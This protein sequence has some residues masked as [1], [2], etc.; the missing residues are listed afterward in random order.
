MSEDKPFDRF[1]KES[2]LLDLIGRV[3]QLYALNRNALNQTTSVNLFERIKQCGE[4]CTE[5]KQAGEDLISFFD[6]EMISDKGQHSGMYY[7]A[8]KYGYQLTTVSSD[9]FGP[10]RV[11]FKDGIYGWCVY[12]G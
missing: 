3:N 8:R 7:N 9:S 1:P 2:E 4:P 11:R 10:T 12:Y 6:R 5:L